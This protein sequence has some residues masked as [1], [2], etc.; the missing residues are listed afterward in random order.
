MTRTHVILDVSQAAYAEIREK[1]EATGYGHTII[2]AGSDVERIDMH[3]IALR[4]ADPLGVLSAKVEADA[5][6]NP[7]HPEGACCLSPEESECCYYKSGH[8]GKHEWEER[9]ELAGGDRPF[10]YENNVEVDSH[11]CDH[12]VP[13]GSYCPQCAILERTT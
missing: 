6:L 8:P 12:G 1:L 9:A 4:T 11:P 13:L 3:G 10:L 5:R 7:R 2:D